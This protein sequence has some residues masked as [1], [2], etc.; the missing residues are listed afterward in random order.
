MA[1]DNRQTGEKERVAL[2]RREVIRLRCKGNTLDEIADLWNAANPEFPVSRSTI[3]NDVKESLRKAVEENKLDTSQY[4][5]LLL[6]RLDAAL[7]ADKFQAQIEKGNLLAIDRLI[8]LTERYAKLL[9]A[10][11][12][13]KVAQTDP[14]GEKEANGLTD[15]ERAERIRE[16]LRRA[17]ERKLEVEV[18]ELLKSE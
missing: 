11:A 3:A 10:D 8:K 4:R 12:P 9:G 13:T 18:E 16:I 2:R 1:T 7:K 15:A 6:M 14:T 17:E 5:E